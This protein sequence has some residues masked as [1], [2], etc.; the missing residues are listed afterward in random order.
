MITLLMQVEPVRLVSAS[1]SSAPWPVGYTMT[2]WG[3]ALGVVTLTAVI[4]ATWMRLSPHARAALAQAAALRL[5]PL[6]L[7]A[8]RSAARA[9]GLHTSSLLIARGAMETAAGAAADSN[10]SPA[11]MRRLASVARRLYSADR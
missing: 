7:L 6:E 2:V 5:S 10:A 4:V 1:H 3:V 9:G 8:V 11:T